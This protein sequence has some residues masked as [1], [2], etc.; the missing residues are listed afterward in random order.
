MIK[1]YEFQLCS[2]L[3]QALSSL[4]VTKSE[5]S[6]EKKKDR[7]RSIL[8][9]IKAPFEEKCELPEWFNKKEEYTHG[10]HELG[11]VLDGEQVYL[12]CGNVVLRRMEHT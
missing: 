10:E 4:V 2:V 8:D 12:I 7:L 6:T 5:K 3:Q 1:V 9:T 11:N